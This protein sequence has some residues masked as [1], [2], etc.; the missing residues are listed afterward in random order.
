MNRHSESP[1]KFKSIRNTWNWFFFESADPRLCAVIRVGFGL[2]L[3]IVLCVQY[4]DVEQWYSSEGWLP[5][6][7]SRKVVD[8]DTGT[9]FQWLPDDPETVHWCYSFFFLQTV[10]L[11][12]GV[13]SRFQ[14]FCVFVWLTTFHHRNCMIIDGEDNVFR[15]YAFLLALSPCG[16]RWSFDNWL[17]RIRRSESVPTPPSGAW[18]VRLMQLQLTLI[19]VSTAWEKLNG[20]AWLDGTALYYTS[21]L[22]D[23]FGRGPVPESLFNSLPAI[24]WMTWSIVVVEVLLPIGLWIR[25]TRRWSILLGIGLH[26]SIEWMMNLFLFEW[27]MI[28]VLFSFATAD[29]LDWFTRVLRSCRPSRFRIPKIVEE[30]CC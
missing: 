12:F 8:P 1:L 16:C 19:Y 21:R 29:D 23:W 4:P 18:A 27:I 10:L 25:E 22:D 9:L 26:L 13:C 20:H 7:V 24:R 11:C 28:L 17:H 15:I 5:Y 3:L 6:D 30:R 2:L 14:A